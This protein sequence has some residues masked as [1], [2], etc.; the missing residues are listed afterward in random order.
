MVTGPDVIHGP[1]YLVLSLEIA[2]KINY[3]NQLLDFQSVILSTNQSLSHNCCKNLFPG[4]RSCCKVFFQDLA[5][6]AEVCVRDLVAAVAVCCRERKTAD[7]FFPFPFHFWCWITSTHLLSTATD[8]PPFLYVVY[9]CFCLLCCSLS[10]R[11]KYEEELAK[12]LW[13]INVHD[14][15][16]K[17]RTGSVSVKLLTATLFDLHG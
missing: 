14:I 13:K 8:R 2:Y 16:F 1:T 9:V 3:I 6:A 17:S 7:I 12:M 5:A 4:S 15:D 11:R 10:R